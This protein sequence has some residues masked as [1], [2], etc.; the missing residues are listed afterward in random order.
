M[1]GE[2]II[3]SYVTC[4]MCGRPFLDA[5]HKQ[6]IKMRNKQTGKVETL[7]FCCKGCGYGYIDKVVA[8]YGP[9]FE[10]IEN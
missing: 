5:F 10:I 9:I 1:F 7:D 2:A 4:D 6:R 8:T 3:R